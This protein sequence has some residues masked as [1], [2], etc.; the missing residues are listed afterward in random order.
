VGFTRL[1]VQ[2]HSSALKYTSTF[3]SYKLLIESFKKAQEV[4]KKKEVLDSQRQCK[5]SHRGQALYPSGQE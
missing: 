1:P 3:T 2:T 4:I 5:E